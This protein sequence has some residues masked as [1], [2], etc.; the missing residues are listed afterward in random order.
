M[1][2]YTYFLYAHFLLNVGVAG[3]LLWMVTHAEQSDVV[4]ACKQAITNTQAQDQCTG[5]LKIT[6]TIFLVVGFAV[7]FI[8]LYGALIATRYLL[9]LKGEKRYD[10]S[11]RMMARPR[12][13]YASLGNSGSSPRHNEFDPYAHYRDESLSFSHSGRYMEL[14]EDTKVPPIHD[15]EEAGYGGGA[16]TNEQISQYEKSISP[17]PEIV[18]SREASTI[19]APVARPAKSFIPEALLSYKPQSPDSQQSTKVSS[20]VSFSLPSSPEHKHRT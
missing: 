3:Y 12:S 15:D 4:K 11:S 6:K 14:S 7:L 17:E 18:Q 9:Q 5:L 19:V 16:W 1:A 13:G 10:R 2:M 8:E 20:R